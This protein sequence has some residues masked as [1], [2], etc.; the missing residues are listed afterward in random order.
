MAF[1]TEQEEFW[2]GSFGD[3]Y[4]ARNKSAGLNAANLQL[5]SQILGHT[6]QVR[7]ILELGANIGMNLRALRTLVPE[8][9]VSGIEI[10]PNAIAELEKVCNG[11]AILGSL[12]ETEVREN[13]DFVF[14]KGVLIHIDPSQLEKVY[15]LL[16]ATSK[17]YI[18]VAEY[19]NPSPVAIPYRGHENRL[20]KRDFAGEL[21]TRHS[22]LSLL[23]YG[24]CYR[25]DPNFPQDD[26]TWFL[27]EKKA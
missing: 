11:K 20:F 9:V 22:D 1:Q 21:L 14:T 19:Y 4:I 5:F 13:Y 10:N 24:F 7:E 26:I 15:D 2:A 12:L 23:G 16:Y 25:N 6:H 27:I 18:C 17:R 3:E 8:A